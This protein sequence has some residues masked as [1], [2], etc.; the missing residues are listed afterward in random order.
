MNDV[1]PEEVTTCE[2]DLAEEMRR[3]E[4]EEEEERYNVL[5]AVVSGSKAARLVARGTLVTNKR[6][7]CVGTLREGQSTVSLLLALW[8]IAMCCCYSSWWWW[9]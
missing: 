6:F 4:E 1:T 9:W 8:E 5:A 3:E 2:E 7:A